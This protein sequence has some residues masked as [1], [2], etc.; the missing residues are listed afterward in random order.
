ML[1][2]PARRQDARCQTI[3]GHSTLRFHAIE[4]D[5]VLERVHRL[6][7]AVMAMRDEQL[8]ARRGAAKGFSTSSSP[9]IDVVEDLLAQA[10][11]SRR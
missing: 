9:F 7:E 10:R 11:R 6:P 4:G 8:L 1:K 5:L 2:A 3:H